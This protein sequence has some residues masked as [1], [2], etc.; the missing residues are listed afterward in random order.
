[1]ASAVPPT[2]ATP[3]ATR[4]FH[5]RKLPA[6]AIA[7]SSMEGQ[8]LFREALVK[9]GMGC[10]FRLIEQFR[11]QDEPAFCG[12]GTLTMVLNAMNV[13]PGR[14]W[15][16]P[17]RWF[18]ETMLDC[19]EPLE[20][21]KEKGITFDKVVCLARCNGA[22]VEAHRAD[23]PAV[24]LETFREA[25]RKTC[26]EATGCPERDGQKSLKVLI[27][28]YSRKQFHQTG[29]GHYSPI[30]GYHEETDKVLVLDVARFKHPPHWVP[31]VE[32]W[33][34]MCRVDQDTMRKRGFMILSPRPGLGTTWLSLAW[35][36]SDQACLKRGCEGEE[37]PSKKMRCIDTKIEGFPDAFAA[38]LVGSQQLPAD[39]SGK[40]AEVFRR[41][42]DFCDGQFMPLTVVFRGCVSSDAQAEAPSDGGFQE[43]QDALAD[44]A[45]KLSALAGRSLISAKT[46]SEVENSSGLQ[47]EL[48]RAAKVL[49]LDLSLWEAALR[50]KDEAV[51]AWEILRSALS[52]DALSSEKL[53]TEV[54]H[55][56]AQCAD[57]VNRKK[58]DDACTTKCGC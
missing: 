6:P 10:F 17:W 26:N 2:A 51:D 42:L 21:I 54:T 31:L 18:H 7:F 25:V 53:R 41:A 3:P 57:L 23:E 39:A 44:A 4:T 24:D 11:T 30:A 38:A 50:S 47:G 20:L 58:S 52:A 1:M 8:K 35:S 28:S 46:D 33:E 34:A 15:K 36:D 45:K 48:L 29:D 37:S 9:G 22:F 27:V 55:L 32:M 19:C 5:R 49:S 40:A 12:L 14:T 16:G 56:R 13:D 43:I